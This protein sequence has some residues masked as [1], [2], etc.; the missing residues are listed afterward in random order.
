MEL[1]S[2]PLAPKTELKLRWEAKATR[3]HSSLALAHNLL[4][5]GQIIKILASTT[6]HVPTEEKDIIAYKN[7]LEYIEEIWTANTKPVTF[8]TVATIADLALTYPK[9]AILRAV[10]TAE[11]PIKTTLEY[12]ENQTDHPVIQAGIALCLLSTSAAIPGDSGLLAR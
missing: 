1:L 8:M 9:D 10:K 6:R 5:R 3:I 7:A 11:T 4:S 12:L 2:I